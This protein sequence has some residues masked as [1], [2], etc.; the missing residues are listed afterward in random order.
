MEDFFYGYVRNYH[1]FH[2]EP[3][4]N[5][6]KWTNKILGFYDQ[7]GTL[8]GVRT[9][10]EWK[11]YDLCWFWKDNNEPWLHVEHENVGSWGAL[12]DTIQKVNDSISEDIIAIVY[13]ESEELWIQFIK[14]MDKSQKEWSKETEVLAIL[15]ASI[16]QTKLVKIEGHVYSKTAGNFVMNAVKKVDEEGIYYAILQ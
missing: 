14:E 6:T 13:P 3:N 4:S 16:F 1:S 10:Y 5:N 7:L 11:R 9:E 2:I 12:N 15:D 8:L